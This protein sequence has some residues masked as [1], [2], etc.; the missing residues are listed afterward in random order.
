MSLSAEEFGLFRTK[1]PGKLHQCLQ[2]VRINSAAHG[3]EQAQLKRARTLLLAE[4][5]QNL[6]CN[7]VDGVAK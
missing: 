1:Q 4:A 3:L 7:D 6:A 5:L 2:Q